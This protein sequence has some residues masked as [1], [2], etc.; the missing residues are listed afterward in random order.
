LTAKREPSAMKTAF[1][2]SAKAP[3]RLCII[4]SPRVSWKL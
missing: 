2:T 3:L 4:Y 1:L